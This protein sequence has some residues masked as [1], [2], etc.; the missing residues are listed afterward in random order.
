[1][2]NTVYA[3]ELDLLEEI[4]AKYGMSG[5]FRVSSFAALAAS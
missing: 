2:K 4:A 3:D 1:M 5:S